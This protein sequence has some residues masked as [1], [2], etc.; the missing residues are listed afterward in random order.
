MRLV[1]LG[2]ED[3]VPALVVA[4][5]FDLAPGGRVEKAADGLGGG[6]AQLQD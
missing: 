5:D 4:A 3:A 6:V 2:L 1:R